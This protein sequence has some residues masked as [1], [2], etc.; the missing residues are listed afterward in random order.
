MGFSSDGKRLRRKS[1][2]R[3][4]GRSR[5]SSECCKGAQRRAPVFGGIHGPSGGEG[6]ARAWVVGPVGAD[7]PVVPGRRKAADG[8]L[9]SR[10]L[11][12]LS[13]AD[14]RSALAA[15]SKQL[16]TR[17][18]QIAHDFLVR[19]IRHAEADDLVDRNVAA[20]VGPF[21][22]QEGRPSKGSVGR[23]GREA[24]EGGR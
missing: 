13:A 8:R 7:D 3:P 23:A 1:P 10:P 14:V 5:T 4:S 15:L 17:L 2:V 12:K 6:L 22:G 24:S 16:S 11:R 20:L 21:A 18:L 19:A 9:G